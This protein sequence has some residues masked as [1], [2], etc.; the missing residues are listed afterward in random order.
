MLK[1]ATRDVK[2]LNSEG[3]EMS[4]KSCAQGQTVRIVDLKRRVVQII[5]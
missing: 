1:S 2:A 5:D 4:R 3:V